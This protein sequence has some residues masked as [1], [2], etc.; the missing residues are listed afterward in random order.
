M[1]D[2]KVPGYDSRQMQAY[3]WGNVSAAY[4]RVSGAAQAANSTLAVMPLPIGITVINVTLRITDAAAAGDQIDVG[5]ERAKSSDNNYEL[6][7]NNVSM[8]ATSQQGNSEP[9]QVLDDKTS[10]VVRFPNEIAS[11][12]AWK[13]T[14]LVTYIFDGEKL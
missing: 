7:F 4:E 10:L 9:Y 8:A 5:V 2:K 14:I 11:T 6:F 13:F 1:A 3:T 12:A